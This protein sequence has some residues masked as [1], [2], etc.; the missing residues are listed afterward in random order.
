MAERRRHLRDAVT[1]PDA[2]VDAF[3]GGI[4]FDGRTMV[5]GDDQIRVS[6]LVAFGFGLALGALAGWYLSWTRH[7]DPQENTDA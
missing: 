1:V 3:I 6:R 4:P 5:I 2:A 7:E